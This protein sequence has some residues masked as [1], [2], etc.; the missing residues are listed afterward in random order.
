MK[1]KLGLVK[2]LYLGLPGLKVI[3]A[4]LK[5]MV[6]WDILAED[7]CKVCL[8]MLIKYFLQYCLE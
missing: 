2:Q 1:S 8:N 7:K 3:A 6:T 5:K 4:V